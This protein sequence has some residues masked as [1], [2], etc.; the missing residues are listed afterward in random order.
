MKLYAYCVCAGLE[1]IAKPIAGVSG[2]SVRLLKAED[3]SLMVSD[4]ESLPVSKDQAHLIREHAQAHAAV[5]RSVLEQTTP[6]PFRF[7][8]LAAE[9]QLRSFIE[10]HRLALTKKLEHVRGC[11]EMDLKIIWQ[12]SDSSAGA[13]DAGAEENDKTGPGTTFLREKQ[14]AL[15]G[16]KQAA[17]QR[18]QLTKLLRREL[19]GILRDEAVSLRQSEAGL[20]SEVFHL[21]ESSGIQQYKEKV[22]ELLEKQPEIHFMISGPWP[23]YGFA[24]MELE[25]DALFG[26]S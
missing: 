7:G 6:L 13:V 24:N 1:T 19:G 20:L 17:E 11:V 9:P 3:L 26:V 14:Q 2:A 22:T 21:V 25:F 23:P 18:T 5:V 12:R 15:A 16:P 4:C 8:T 10:T